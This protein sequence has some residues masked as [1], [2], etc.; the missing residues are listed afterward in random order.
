MYIHKLIIFN[1]RASVLK[2]YKVILLNSFS[3]IKLI[4]IWKMKNLYSKILVNIRVINICKNILMLRK[5]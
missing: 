2:K 3:K 1:I 5:K 4:K